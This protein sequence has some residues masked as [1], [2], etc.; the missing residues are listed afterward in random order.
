MLAEYHFPGT[1]EVARNIIR[2]RGSQKNIWTVGEPGLDAFNREKL[3]SR[4]ELARDIG[5]D[6]NTY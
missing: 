1:D 4:E 3:L 5:L 2:M 6:V